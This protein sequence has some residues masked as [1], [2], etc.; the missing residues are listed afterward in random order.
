[1]RFLLCGERNWVTLIGTAHFRLRTGNGRALE[2]VAMNILMKRAKGR[3]PI[4]REK[5]S[6]LIYETEKK[7]YHHHCFEHYTLSEAHH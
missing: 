4:A 3:T 1:M 5:S 2:E 6:L 7:T